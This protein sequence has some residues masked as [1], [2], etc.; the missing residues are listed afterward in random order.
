MFIR[1]LIA[2]LWRA[3]A[4]LS[5]LVV[6]LSA[7][8]VSAAPAAHADTAPTCAY[9][10]CDVV[11]NASWGAVWE[12]R[13]YQDAVW[14]GDRTEDSRFNFQDV[15]D[16]SVYIR[17]ARDH[18]VSADD[19]DELRA[20]PCTGAI[21]QRWYFQNSDDNT[22]VLRR[23][24]KNDGTADDR[25][26]ETIRRVWPP[27]SAMELHSC[28]SSEIF[29]QHAYFEGWDKSR[30]AEITGAVQARATRWAS[31]QCDQ[32]KWVTCS[33]LAGATSEPA[34]TAPEP[35][36]RPAYNFTQTPVPTTI[37]LSESK[38]VTTS[39][40]YTYKY[41]VKFAAGIEGFA[42]TEWTVEQSWNVGK[43]WT[44][45]QALAQTVTAMVPANGVAWIA[46]AQL[47]RSITGT[48]TFVAKDTNQRWTDQA[49]A[50]FP[51][52]DSAGKRS[53][54]FVCDD[55][56][57]QKICLDSSPVARANERARRAAP[58]AS[59]EWLTT[60]N[61][62]DHVCTGTAVSDSWVIT[63]TQCGAKSVHYPTK[64]GRGVDAGVDRIVDSPS[65]GV[66]MV[67]L[68]Q[69]VPLGSY[70]K[71]DT[72]SVVPVGQSLQLYSAGS[73]ADPVAIVVDGAADSTERDQLGGG[74]LLMVRTSASRATVSDL[75]APVLLNGQVVGVLQVSKEDGSS[76]RNGY[77]T[78]RS[79]SATVTSVLAPKPSPS[80][81]VPSKPSPS[82][83]VPGKPSPS[84]SPSVPGKPAPSP[85]I[86]GKPAPSPSSTPVDADAGVQQLSAVDGLV[87]LT[88]SHDLFFSRTR[89]MIWADE[90][91]AGE[92]YDGHAYYLGMRIN[93][94]Q[95]VSVFAR[96][97]P[98]AVVR[99]GTHAG[100]PGWGAT[101]KTTTIVRAALNGAPPR[102]QRT[103]SGNVEVA[104]PASVVAST[105]RVMIFVNGKYVGETWNGHRYYLAS[106][107]DGAAVIVTPR[108]T[109]APGDKVEV[110]LATGTPG[111]SFTDYAVVMRQT[112]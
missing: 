1:P 42:K 68:S 35:I 71:I 63:A 7:G 100:V 106:R 102:V 9:D 107:N 66:R 74:D 27:R 17:D 22:F 60:V 87:T 105:R 25:C 11:I 2:H 109:F 10:V 57:T 21:G 48:I 91:Y 89:L 40:G 76:T 88:V 32:G 58:T 6:I 18:C 31:G 8:V 13:S 93:A 78:A 45:T 62:G 51:A 26:T 38:S 95:S 111:Q 54:L 53:Q 44:D 47:T 28:R 19:H 79:S 56:S 65:G 16:G 81:S 41:S 39:F 112:L 34:L 86:P 36:G 24:G 98:G 30:N 64:D 69:K 4:T 83:S 12:S 37:Q 84:P 23:V 55:R 92:M 33:Y 61:D 97:D 72:T 67:H 77:A 85:S 73:P 52:K 101:V 43:A 15:G 104:L 50:T 94:D 96:V 14:W 46:Y 75:G 5:A 108:G 70:P 82:P 20:V 29:R 49:T 99:V 103:K 59:V 3:L 80:P 90:K 110:R